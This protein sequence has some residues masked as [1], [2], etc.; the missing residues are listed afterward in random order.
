MKKPGYFHINHVYSYGLS[1]TS[2]VDMIHTHTH[3]LHTHT[4]SI[5]TDILTYTMLYKT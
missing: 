2:K 1:Q 5:Y 4:D 3:I